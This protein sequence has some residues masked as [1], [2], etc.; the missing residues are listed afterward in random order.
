MKN[1]LKILA[2][3]ITAFT[4]QA[5][6]TAT[7]TG[8]NGKSE[9]Q[10]IGDSLVQDVRTNSTS[11][12]LGNS[13]NAN[14]ASI[15]VPTTVDTRDQNTV[16]VNPTTTSQGGTSNATGNTSD[17]RS[18]VG[19]TS[20]SNGGNTVAGTVTGANTST[21]TTTSA[22]GT[23]GNTSAAGGAGGSAAG[24]HASST[25]AG[26]NAAQR[27]GQRQSADNQVSTGA[28]TIAVDSADRSS[29]SYRAVAFAP[30][31]H[32]PAAPALAAGPM[33]VVPGQC[34][35]RV[36]IVRR[37]VVGSRFGVWGGQQDVL[38]GQ[39]EITAPAPEPFVQ[40]GP[41][42]MGH[43]VTVYTAVLGTSSAA[44]LS[45]AG[46]GKEGQGAQGGGSTGGQLQQMVQ[47][48]AVR[49][50]VMAQMAALEAV[51]REPVALVQPTRQDRN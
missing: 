30:V 21:N 32:G 6:Q 15:S 4:A 9:M 11:M 40:V 48:I 12:Q 44:S 28:T 2:L 22:G 8:D 36:L 39:D 25:S 20:A 41:Y 50:C 7:I 43:S 17:N 31:I 45:L 27:Q 18:S 10:N 24:G 5:E 26:G 42:L 3:S 47:R 38:Q 37:D 34:G 19:N 35:P 51:Q 49:E 33:V 14:G 23:V 46:Y 16:A 13:A 1:T 29:S